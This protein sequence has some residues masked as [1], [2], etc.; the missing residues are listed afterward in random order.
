MLAQ[1]VPDSFKISS[2]VFNKNGPFHWKAKD[3]TGQNRKY[4]LQF[5]VE[6]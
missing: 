2:A 3:K 4:L 6:V 5:Y 1:V